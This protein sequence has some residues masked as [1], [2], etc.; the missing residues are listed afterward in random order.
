MKIIDK[1]KNMVKA[2]GR[3]AKTTHPQE[4]YDLWADDYDEQ[5]G[6]LMLDLDEQIFGGLLNSIAVEN[7]QIADIGCGTGR[8]WKA[9]QKK[10][11][12]QLTGFDVSEGM[13][14][15]LKEKYPKSHTVHLVKDGFDDIPNGKYD[16]IISTLTIAHIQNLAVAIVEWSRILRDE[17]DIIITDFHPGMLAKGGKRTFS[18][19]GIPVTIKNYIHPLESIKTHFLNNG[20]TMQKEEI[21]YVDETVRPYYIKKNAIDVYD[22]FR[23]IPV[24]YGLHFTR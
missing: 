7:K 10:E 2:S 16:I 19:H 4:A 24:I 5:P 1:V 22:R 17:G 14:K 23:G 9:I 11:P 15:K 13:L 8:H 20:F 6:N 21:R 18:H 3:I 12:A